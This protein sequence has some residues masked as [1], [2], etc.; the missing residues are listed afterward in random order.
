MQRKYLSNQ[1]KNSDADKKIQKLGSVI[2]VVTILRQIKYKIIRRGN[3]DGN[4]IESNFK[5]K[6]HILL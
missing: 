1:I 2:N 3:V 6:T 4:K 5:V